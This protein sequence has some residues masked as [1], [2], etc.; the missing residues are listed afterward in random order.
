MDPLCL[1][2]SILSLVSFSTEL[3]KSAQNLRGRLEAEH[4]DYL[5]S[6][7]Q[8]KHA[9]SIARTG[10]ARSNRMISRDVGKAVDLANETSPKESLSFC[11]DQAIISLEEE[12]YLKTLR[13]SLESGPANT[14][15]E[16]WDRIW[17][18]LFPATSVNRSDLTKTVDPPFYD[19]GDSSRS[20]F[21]EAEPIKSG[22]WS[23][24]SR[25]KIRLARMDGYGDGEDG[26]ATF[27]VKKICSGNYQ[28]YA[29]ERDAL[30]RLSLAQSPHPHIVP[31]LASYRVENKYH[32]VFPSADCDLAMFWRQQPRP[33]IDKRT[34]EWFGGQMR[35]LADALYTIHG[36]NGQERKLRGVHGDLKPENILC[37]GSNDSER[38]PVLA[39]TDFGSSYFLTPE[40]KD[41]PKS[42]KHTPAYRAPE[43]DTA[44]LGGIT[45]AYDVWSLGCIFAEAIA[46]FYNGKAGIAKLIQAR[47]DEK[48]NSPNRDAFFQLQYDKRDG[49]T[50]K[51]KPG[52]HRVCLLFHPGI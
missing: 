34:L 1:A 5:R 47:L 16:K 30:Q 22:G 43:I 39:I 25:V 37:F 33:S 7:Q 40:E 38:W 23:Q 27:A 31:L 48:D 6:L 3:F 2:G 14:D 50:A 32:L 8:L 11:L 26:K 46:W 15:I 20:I 21:D 51:L 45:Q 36:Q 49:L 28:Q 12:A 19:F 9:L 41:I 29:R 44:T 13:Q 52:V 35:G 42:L 17:R 4:K 18:K 24:V 10:L